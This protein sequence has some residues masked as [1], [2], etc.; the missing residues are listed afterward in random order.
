MYKYFS[1]RAIFSILA[2]RVIPRLMERDEAEGEGGGGSGG[3]E[4]IQ[5]G[6]GEQA[7]RQQPGDEDV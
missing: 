1:K 7:N 5:Q 2:G 6:D 3:P 4:E